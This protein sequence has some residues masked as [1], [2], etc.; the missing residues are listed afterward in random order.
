MVN[1][2]MVSPANG[3]DHDRHPLLD[4]LVHQPVA[5]V[6]E[7]DFVTVSGRPESLADTTCGVSSRLAYISGTSTHEEYP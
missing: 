5:R 3:N 6:S 2:I 7:F 4:D 1:P